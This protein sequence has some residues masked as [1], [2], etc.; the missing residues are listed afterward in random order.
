MLK[1]FNYN[2]GFLE[3]NTP[4]IL[5]IQ[6][7]NAL[8]DTERNKCSDDP[9]GLYSKRA[10]REFTYIYLAL[11]WNSPYCEYF[12]QEKHQDALKDANMT[13]E[14]FNDP[15]FRAA[16]RKYKEMQESDRSIKLLNAARLT[17]DKFVNYFENIDPEERDETTRK[18]VYKV[19][20]IMAEI[21]SLNKVYES[22]TILDSQVKKQLVEQTQIRGNAEEGYLPDDL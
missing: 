6:E 22:L 3:L 8:M 5:L 15:L 9:K 14:E 11:D 20:D 7:F 19:K 17:I 4:E 1:F 2:G 13:E 21:T 12:A 16:C 10:F 18:P